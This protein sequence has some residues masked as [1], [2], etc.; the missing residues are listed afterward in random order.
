[1]TPTDIIKST[2][3]MRDVAETY[4]FAPNRAGFIACPFH[5]EKTASLKIYPNDRGWHCFGCGVGGDVISFV[6][7]LFNLDFPAAIVRLSH[8]F[9]LNVTDKRPDP[10]ERHRI[11]QERRERMRAMQAAE[12]EL[13]DLGVVFRTLRH[14]RQDKPPIRC[15]DGSIH[16]D[17]EWSAACHWLE[18]IDY[19][20][21][22]LEDDLRAMKAR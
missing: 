18:Y 12:N 10:S 5:G 11:A 21:G 17:P 1:M 13:V 20:I 4:G 6:Q 3:T 22:V 7:K 16:I 15:A 14:A 2:L 19:M 8:D 9:N